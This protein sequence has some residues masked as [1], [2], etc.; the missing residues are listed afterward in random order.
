MPK[1]LMK[2]KI[3]YFEQETLM[4]DSVSDAVADATF[5][6]LPSEEF[7]IFNVE[8]GERVAAYVAADTSKVF[9]SP[10]DRLQALKEDL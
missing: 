4:F 3:K 7:E 8:T 2:S 1:Y 5:R 10:A 9:M 6:A